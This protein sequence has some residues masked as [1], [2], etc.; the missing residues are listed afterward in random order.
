MA[1]GARGGA[2]G[3]VGCAGKGIVGWAGGGGRGGTC[4]LQAEGTQEAHAVAQPRGQSEGAAERAA[5]EEELELGVVAR[6]A[7]A[8]VPQRHGGLVEV[9]EQRPRC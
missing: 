9:C 1:T 3:P 8:P 7:R 4:V 5:A 6:S 2:L